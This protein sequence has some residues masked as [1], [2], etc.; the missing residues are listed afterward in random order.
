VPQNVLITGACPRRS[1]S[2]A[3][4]DLAA[5]HGERF[6]EI[7]L[8]VADPLSLAD[9]AGEVGR[10]TDR[11]DLLF[12]NAGIYPKDNGGIEALDAEQLLEAFRVNVVGSLMVVRA[13]LPLLRRGSAKRLIQITSLMG[14]ITDNTTGGSYAYRLSKTAL[15]MA[16]RNLAHDLA[17]EGFVALAI[18][19]GWVRT[20]MGGRAA[21][22]E[23]AEAAREVLRLA[24]ETPPEHN[25]SFV[26]PGGTILPY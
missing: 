8:D 7:P 18:H 16:T 12:N 15:N 2:A 10:R 19:P 3:L 20:D 5:A 13:L 6:H 9:S 17:G 22:L 25:G 4:A 23:I 14:S 21:P 26:G 24:R 1:G 11:I